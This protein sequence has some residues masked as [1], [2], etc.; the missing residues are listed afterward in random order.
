VPLDQ[1]EAF[2][3]WPLVFGPSAENTSCKIPT[4]LPPTNAAK[5]TTTTTTTTTTS[6]IDRDFTFQ[7]S[8]YAYLFSC[9][10][11]LFSYYRKEIEK[12][13]N[14]PIQNNTTFSIIFMLCE[15]AE[16]LSKI[17]IKSRRMMPF[18]FE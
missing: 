14:T 3:Q 4:S 6:I 17:R 10:L 15:A 2:A 12:L 16:D 18:Y 1:Q 5:I 13:Y 7:L 9:F 8:F 11:L